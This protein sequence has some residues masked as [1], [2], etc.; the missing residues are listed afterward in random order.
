VHGD[1]GDSARPRL[2]RDEVAEDDRDGPADCSAAIVATGATPPPASTASIISR[3][4]FLT[5]VTAR[6]ASADMKAP[7]TCSKSYQIGSGL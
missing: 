4:I 7:V 1:L 6:A 3:W 2:A 5:S